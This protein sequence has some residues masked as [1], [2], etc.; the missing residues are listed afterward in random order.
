ME[1]V[2]TAQVE[3]VVLLFLVELPRTMYQ[4]ELASTMLQVEFAAAVYQVRIYQQLCIS[5]VCSDPV[6]YGVGFS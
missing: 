1:L 3:L 4:L 2:G 5:G 6:L